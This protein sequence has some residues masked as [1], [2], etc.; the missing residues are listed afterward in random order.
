MPPPLVLSTLPLL[1]KTPIEAPSPLVLWR[2]SSRMTLVCR[3]V[4]AMSVIVRLRHASNFVDQPHHASILD[5]PSLFAPAGCSMSCRRH[6][7]R[8]RP[9]SSAAAACCCAHCEEEH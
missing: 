8:L 1:L 3:L 4:V 7:R 6:R 2:L 5:P 9:S